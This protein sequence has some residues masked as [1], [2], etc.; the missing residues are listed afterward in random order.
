MPRARR[1]IRAA[2][3]AASRGGPSGAQAERG[4]VGERVKIVMVRVRLRPGATFSC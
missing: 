2:E 3:A 4:H 1:R